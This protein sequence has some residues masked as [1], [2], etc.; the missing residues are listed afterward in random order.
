M[1]IRTEVRVCASRMLHSRKL[2][3]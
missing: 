2:P 1:K 3:A